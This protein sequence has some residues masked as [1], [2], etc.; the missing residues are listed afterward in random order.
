MIVKI[1]IFFLLAFVNFCFSQQ[2]DSLYTILADTT[3]VKLELKNSFQ[4]YQIDAN[5]KRV[6][7]KPKLLEVF[8]RLPKDFMDTNRDFVAKDHA[9]YLGGSIAATAL[10][11]PFDQR[12][13]DGTRHFADQIGLSPDNR[14]GKFGPLQNIPQNTGAG[15]YLFGNGTTVII[16]SAGFVTYGLLKNDYRAQ[17][18]ASGLLESL[19]LSGLYVQVLK[20]S[21]GRESPFIARENGHPGGDWNPF[22]SFAAYAKETPHYDAVPS[23]HLATIM[24]AVTIIA[25]NYPEYK[26][27]K[28]VSYTLLGGLCFQ[29][30]QSEVHWA[31]DYPLALLIGYFAGKNI[32]KNRF[33]DYNTKVSGVE[34][35]RRY[36]LSITGSQILDYKMLGLNLKF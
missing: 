16:L 7:T 15:L 31:S 33:K 5:T 23:G 10:L 3:K 18:T 13:T 6:F 36:N 21:I 30:M 1:K 29:M 26:W 20:R 11:V 28:P 2:K 8:T 19:A 35:V 22:P 24:S 32:A 14:Y 25:T 12:I 27:I 34:K 17:A 4:E 9:W